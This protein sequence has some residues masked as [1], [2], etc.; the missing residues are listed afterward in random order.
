[1][2]A[3]A[4]GQYIAKW[5]G[6]NR[7]GQTHGDAVK[8]VFQELDEISK[9]KVHAPMKLLSKHVVLHMFFVP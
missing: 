7:G 8:L 6:F 1:M 3:C 9:R 5:Q 2:M 4:D